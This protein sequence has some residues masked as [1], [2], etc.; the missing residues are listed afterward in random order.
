MLIS[1]EGIVLKAHNYSEADLMITF[2]TDKMG[3]INVYGK[4]A[5]KIKSK[6]SQSSQSLAYS[7][8]NLDYSGG[9]Y[10]LHSCEL[11]DNFY[12][13]STDLDKYYCAFYML[14][15]IKRLMPENQG[16]I[17]AFKLIVEILTLLK[18][19]DDIVLLKL[20]FR[21]KLL[22]YM[23]IKPQ[24]TKCIECGTSLNLKCSFAYELGGMIC[25]N[26]RQ[27]SKEGADLFDK[28][29][30][31]AFDYLLENKV[32][33]CLKAKISPIIINQIEELLDKYY[34]QNF[35]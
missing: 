16:N 25:S 31:L 15:I 5:R 2:F 17:R 6:I 11:I 1:A 32:E 30:F 12:N 35:E 22:I 4:N 7:K 24:L 10:K 26:C 8:I 21:I 14:D 29:T 9:M 19:N 13:L 23:G 27:N 18:S 28:T 33:D 3:K 20:I 34:K